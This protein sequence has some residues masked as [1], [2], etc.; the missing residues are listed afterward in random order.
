MRGGLGWICQSSFRGRELERNRA[1][2]REDSSAIYA[3]LIDC[4]P[5]SILTVLQT[6]NVHVE[7]RGAC[8]LFRKY[9]AFA[10]SRLLFTYPAHRTPASSFAFQQVE[11]RNLEVETILVAFHKQLPW[12]HLLHFNLLQVEMQCPSWS[13]Q[14]TTCYRKA[15]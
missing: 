7:T 8:A 9:E 10:S 4:L 11:D 2:P 13:M 5:S 1:A 12:F 6:P 14:I 3:N 15:A